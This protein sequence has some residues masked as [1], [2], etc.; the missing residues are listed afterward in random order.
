MNTKEARIEVGKLLDNHCH[1]CENRYSRNLQYCWKKCE[2]GK[3]IN[4]IGVFLGGKVAN[5]Q[6]KRRTTKQWDEICEIT[7]KLK[8]KG[9]TY[10]KDC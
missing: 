1:A 3:R 5:E 8:E 4:Q 9:M 10:K 6:H 7:V 2:I